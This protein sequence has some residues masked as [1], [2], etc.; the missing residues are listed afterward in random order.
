[1]EIEEVNDDM[2]VSTSEEQM[3][4]IS[5]KREKFDDHDEGV[6]DEV[7]QIVEK[8]QKS[9][10]P[11]K[12]V[13]CEIVENSSRV[14]VNHSATVEILSEGDINRVPL[15]LS[16]DGSRCWSRRRE[17][18]HD[19]EFLD[20]NPMT[21]WT[22][23]KDGYNL[24]AYGM[25]RSGANFD[26]ICLQRHQDGKFL[27]TDGN[28][29]CLEFWIDRDPIKLILD[30]KEPSSKAVATAISVVGRGFGVAILIEDYGLVFIQTFLDVPTMITLHQS[31]KLETTIGTD[32]NHIA[33]A[34]GDT[35]LIF[36]ITRNEPP[37]RIPV[38]GLDL[39]QQERI[40]QL[41]IGKDLIAIC[42]TETVK[43]FQ[44]RDKCWKSSDM[45]SVV[46]VAVHSGNNLVA[47]LTALGDIVMIDSNC[48][49]P[50]RRLER[51]SMIQPFVSQH[52]RDGIWAW[53]KIGIYV[54]CI[55]L[56]KAGGEIHQV[57]P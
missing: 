55:R 39:S 44:A 38:P 53:G 42:T 3:L 4:P 1:M 12:S 43:W 22:K 18:P 23:V 52:T 16:S 57:L 6:N 33:V 41:D 37:T 35:I 14:A 56:I 19:L 13:A 30:D 9:C 11:D 51:N 8:K 26:F 36:D 29:R 7:M 45:A 15:C 31:S 32:S 10:A 25:T 40:W 34:D 46:A 54:P 49:S 27:F 28:S 5:N 47:I 21:Q 20:L 48:K 2:I 17:P 24:G 50:P